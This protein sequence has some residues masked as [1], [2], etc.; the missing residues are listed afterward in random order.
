[1]FQCFGM[2]PS[3][4]QTITVS[5]GRNDKMNEISDKLVGLKLEARDRKNPGLFC[6]A[7]ISEIGFFKFLLLE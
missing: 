7:S 6:V 5:A 4:L 2:D 1:M 3:N